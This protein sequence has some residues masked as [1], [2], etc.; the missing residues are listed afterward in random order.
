MEG[1]PAVLARGRGSQKRKRCPEERTVPALDWADA[2][3]ASSKRR[4]N[5]EARRCPPHG[6]VAPRPEARGLVGEPQAPARRPLAAWPARPHRAEREASAASGSGSRAGRPVLGQA[7]SPVPAC[8]EC[9][10]R[11]FQASR[12]PAGDRPG[13]RSPVGALPGRAGLRARRHPRPSPSA[14]HPDLASEAMLCR[15]AARCFA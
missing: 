8:L 10:R 9:H 12:R 13:H 14:S 11:L 3:R 5:G 6:R 1:S 2:K 4:K 15:R 7:S